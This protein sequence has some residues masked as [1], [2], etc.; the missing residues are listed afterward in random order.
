MLFALDFLCLD[1]R[2]RPSCVLSRFWFLFHTG[3]RLDLHCNPVRV[4][5]Y[6]ASCL[7]HWGRLPGLV[8][9]ALRYFLF[10][11]GI[12]VESYVESGLFVEVINHL[13]SWSV[14]LSSMYLA[15]VSIVVLKIRFASSP[16]FTTNHYLTLDFNT[17]L[18]WC[19]SF[20]LSF[21]YYLFIY[22]HLD[23]VSCL[24]VAF[25]R[26]SV[27]TS[28][29]VVLAAACIV[30][31]ARFI[32]FGRVGYYHETALTRAWC[33][34]VPAC[35]TLLSVARHGSFSSLCLATVLVVSSTFD[36]SLNQCP[37]SLRSIV[38]PSLLALVPVPVMFHSAF[39]L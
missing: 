1:L 3:F 27:A 35:V 13:S 11:S 28:P 38:V 24:R 25:D 7:L 2:S 8:R 6:V 37:C 19:L 15:L 34:I 22:F 16:T 5:I 17:I 18:A 21:S 10:E 23:L 4:C 26:D 14:L 39:G 12:M 29:S 20:F 31:R 32:R 33:D 36:V 9:F 30:C